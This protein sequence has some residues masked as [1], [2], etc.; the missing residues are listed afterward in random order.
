LCNELLNDFYVGRSRQWKFYVW[1][2]SVC[3]DRKSKFSFRARRHDHRSYV[4][5][6]G[7]TGAKSRGSEK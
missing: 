6:T 1:K 2:N 7:Y 5:S 3:G 4:D